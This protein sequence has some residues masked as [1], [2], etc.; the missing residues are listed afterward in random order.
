MPPRESLPGHNKKTVNNHPTRIKRLEGRHKKKLLGKKQTH[1]AAV[2]RVAGPSRT[3]KQKRK[4]AHF[5]KLKLQAAADKGDISGADFEMTDADAAKPVAKGKKGAAKTKK[6]SST[7]AKKGGRK[8]P[9]GA[10]AN[11]VADM[12]E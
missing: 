1:E 4:Q 8:A 3:G 12:V 10:E 9:T 7:K 2:A 11:A 6:N 5:L